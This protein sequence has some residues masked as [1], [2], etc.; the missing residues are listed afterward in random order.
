VVQ[1]YVSTA[2]NSLSILN[3]PDTARFMARNEVDFRN[4]RRRKTAFFIIVTSEKLKSYSF[5]LN[6]LHIGLFSTC[7]KQLPIHARQAGNPFLSVYD[8]L[9]EF[10]RSSI[11]DFDTILT[12][13]RKYDVSISMILQSISQLESRYGK[14]EAKTILEGGVRN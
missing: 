13:I 11:P 2:I 4:L 5:I 14:T 8:L 6:L 7:M 10:C 9:N 3:N 12:T 1:S